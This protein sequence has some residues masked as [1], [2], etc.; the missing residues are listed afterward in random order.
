MALVKQDPEAKVTA[1]TEN[2]RSTNV[3]FLQE[4]NKQA[5][6]ALQKVE[7]E[8]NE[9]F[10]VIK[11]WEV[12]QTKLQVHLS[13]TTTPDFSTILALCSAEVVP[14]VKVDEQ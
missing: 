11:E 4:Q 12:K 7:E 6:S 14:L 9:A 3:R 8:R 13:A 1:H 5:L 2:F 10:S